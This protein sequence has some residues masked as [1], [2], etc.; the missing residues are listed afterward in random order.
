MFNDKF[1]TAEKVQAI[2]TDMIKAPTKRLLDPYMAIPSSTSILFLGGEYRS[3]ARDVI[4]QVKALLI[5]WKEVRA[6]Y[7]TLCSEYPGDPHDLLPP[8][9][10]G[11][12]S[13]TSHQNHQKAID[14]LSMELQQ[15]FRQI[16][17]TMQ[18][19]HTLALMT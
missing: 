6:V 19:I 5:Q 14:S 8:Y 9:A 13:E 17:P 2:L 18:Y 10:H 15:S 7:Q 11:C 16:E 4:A 1:A 12:V 3:D